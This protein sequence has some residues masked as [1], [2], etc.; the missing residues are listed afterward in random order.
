M[1]LYATLAELKAALGVTGTADDA[2][3]AIALAGASRLI[4]EQCGRTFGLG[5][6][7][8][9]TF[10]AYSGTPILRIGDVV[11]VSAVATVASEVTTALESTAY[12][13]GPADR[14]TGWPYDHLVLTGGGTPVWW[15]SLPTTVQV[16]GVWGWS[17]V[18]EDVKLACIQ[19]AARWY[20]AAQAGFER[21]TDI[22][23]TGRI[24]ISGDLTEYERLVLKQY[25]VKRSIV[26]A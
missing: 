26:F 12:R 7:E 10:I 5:V 1:T 25:S 6:S 11:S 2:T 15:S 17:A 21:I 16:T 23:G 9:R 3:F 14:R 22:P 8:T 18:P 19:M 13:L 20:R 4:D 24:E